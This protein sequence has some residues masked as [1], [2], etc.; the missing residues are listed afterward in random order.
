MARG[1]VGPRCLELLSKSLL[2]LFS[3]TEGWFL[4]GVCK[5]SRCWIRAGL[6]IIDEEVAGIAL[7]V[8]SLADDGEV[9][10]SAERE[11]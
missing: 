7:R 2:Y 11:V 6:T 9:G 8:E 4:K 1:D 3:E 5:L 10:G